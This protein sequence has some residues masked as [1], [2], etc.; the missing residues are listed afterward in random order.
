MI[1]SKMIEKEEVRLH[2]EN[3]ETASEREIVPI[4]SVTRMNRKNK[5]PIQAIWKC[6][7]ETKF[8]LDTV[9]FCMV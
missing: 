6:E 7:I 1:V 4:K 8:N 3:A 9:G 2:E 5:L